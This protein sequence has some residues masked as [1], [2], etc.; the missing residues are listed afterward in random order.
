MTQRQPNQFTDDAGRT[1]TLRLHLGLCERIREECGVNLANPTDPQTAEVLLRE[2]N[3]PRFLDV[4]WRLVESQAQAAG[5]DRQGFLEALTD[6][7]LCE[8]V[9]ALLEAIVLFSRPAKRPVLQAMADKMRQIQSETMLRVQTQVQQIDVRRLL[10]QA[11]PPSTPSPSATNGEASSASI[12]DPSASGS[13]PGWSA[14]GIAGNGT[15]PP[16]SS[17]PSST[18]APTGAAS[19]SAPAVS[20]PT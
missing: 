9:D 19:R 16:R 1:W 17:A 18:P 5:V 14:D 2:D 11:I 12:P 4:L 3:V 15:I 13:S 7:V 6:A 20:I 10:D 8:A